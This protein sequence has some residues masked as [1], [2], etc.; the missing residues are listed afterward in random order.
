MSIA[1]KDPIG[2]REITRIP[3]IVRMNLRRASARW[4]GLSPWT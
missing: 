2:S 3:A 4:N 1:R